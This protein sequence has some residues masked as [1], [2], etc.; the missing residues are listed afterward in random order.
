MKRS[1]ADVAFSKCIRAA[2]DYKCQRCGKQYDSSSTGLHCSHNFSRRHRTIRWCVD[3]AYALCY[4]CHQWFGSEPYE[5]GK[6]LEEMMGEGAL[7]LLI[8]KK[9]MK[10]KIP[11]AEEKEIAKHYRQ[12]LERISQGHELES[13]Q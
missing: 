9:N 11:T 3:N 6:W 12:Q 5:A 2:A 7:Q 13:Y 1:P 4:S 10:V 8:E